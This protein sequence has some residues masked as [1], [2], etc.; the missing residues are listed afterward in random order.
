MM[1]REQD[2]TELHRENIP[3]IFKSSHSTIQWSA[4]QPAHTYEETT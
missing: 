2:I 1:H 3:E 4:S